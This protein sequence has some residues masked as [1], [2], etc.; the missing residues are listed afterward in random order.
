MDSI[1]TTE[2]TL[3]S[4]QQ[5]YT[6]G[7]AK[8]PM[9]PY[10]AATC[11]ATSSGVVNV[12]PGD[13]PP[14]L[15]AFKYTIPP[16]I[17][18]GIRFHL[19]R[20]KARVVAGTDGEARDPLHDDVFDIEVNGSYT[21]NSKASRIEVRFNPNII[22]Q[23]TAVYVP[24][25]AD[26]LTGYKD[27]YGLRLGGQWNAIPDKLGIRAGGWFE[28]QSQEAEYLQINV[29]GAQRYGF[30]GGLVFRQDFIDISLGYQRLM[31]SALDNGGNGKLLAPAATGG[32]ESE[33]PDINKR[34]FH[35]INGGK[36]TQS[37][38]AFTIGGTIRF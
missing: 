18:A 34:S 12:F 4:E 21:M 3:I 29:V 28:T 17:R 6:A 2:G 27:S 16:E 11:G 37:A 33:D 25:H 14:A 35:A 7:G 9:C 36:L 15:K 13:G 23:P 32:Q 1:R 5:P 38:H 31:S 10:D 24:E 20:T 22:V 26:R 19:P 8:R 30:G